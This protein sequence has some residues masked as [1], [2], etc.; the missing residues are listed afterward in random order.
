MLYLVIE[1]YD[2]GESW[3]YHRDFD[4]VVGVFETRELAEKE[5]EC[6]IKEC[7]KGIYA[8]NEKIKKQ[9]C[10]HCNRSDRD[11]CEKCFVSFEKTETGYTTDM[12]SD[13]SYDYSV[14]EIELNKRIN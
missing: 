3:E 6:V 14:T 12:Y 5:I 13:D 4:T 10:P 9:Q 8:R 7:R 2:N 11:T 1:H